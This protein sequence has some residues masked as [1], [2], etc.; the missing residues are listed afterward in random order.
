MLKSVCLYII[1]SSVL[2]KLPPFRFVTAN[3]TGQAL[4]QTFVN[5][6]DGEEENVPT[7]DFIQDSLVSFFMQE[8]GLLQTLNVKVNLDYGMNAPEFSLT[9][10][11]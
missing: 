6:E 8:Q 9:W 10:Y 11:I 7:E 1:G 5:H 2:N 4:W 3:M